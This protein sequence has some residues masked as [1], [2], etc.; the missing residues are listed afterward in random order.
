MIGPPCQFCGRMEYPHEC[1]SFTVLNSLHY[2]PDGEEHVPRDRRFRKPVCDR[3][4][5]VLPRGATD[6]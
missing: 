1:G 4:D 3:C 5:E 6:G 2:C